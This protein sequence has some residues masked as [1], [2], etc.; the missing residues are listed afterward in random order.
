EVAQPKDEEFLEALEHGMPPAA[1]MGIGIDRFAAILAG[2]P[3]LKEII[4]YPTLRPK[5]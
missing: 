4:L 3:S 5:Q 2:V 1:G